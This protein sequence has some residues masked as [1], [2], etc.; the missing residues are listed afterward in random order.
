MSEE[1]TAY[2]LEDLEGFSDTQLLEILIR[3]WGYEQDKP[4]DLLGKLK[5]IT[6]NAGGS[7]YILEQ[8]HSVID[9]SILAYPL[10]E[11][12]VRQT[13]FVGNVKNRELEPGCWVKARVTLAPETV[14]IKHKNPFS[15]KTVDDS[16]SLLFALPETADSAKYYVEDKLHVE[17]WIV[18]FYHSKN[19]KQ[20]AE[21]KELLLAQLSQD[22]KRLEQEVKTLT[23]LEQSIACEINTSRDELTKNTQDLENLLAEKYDQQQVFSRQKT[24]LE[25]KLN[26]LREY[27]KNT[28]EMLLDLDLISQDDVGALLE[29]RIASQRIIGHD[30]ELVFDRSERQAITYIQAFMKN[31]GILYR[32]S[33]LEDFF[34]LVRTH[35][36]II[37]AGDSGS[38]KTNLVKSFAEAIGG[39]SIIIP[40]KPNWTSA[41]DLLGYYNPLEQK[42]LT[43]P[44]LDALFEAKQ[45]PEIPYFICLDEMNLARVEYYFADFLSLLEE[46]NHSPEIS[47]YSDS[48]SEHLLSEARNFLA[49]I[50]DSKT[51]MNK[52]DLISF[53]DLMRD[54][55][56]NAKLHELC[57]FR[58]GDSLLKYHARLRKMLQS[59]LSTPAKL[60]LPSNVRII[61]AINVDE[62]THYLSPKILDRAHLIRFSSPLLTDWDEIEQE[63]EVFDLD[64]TL[65]VCFH[66]NELGLRQPYPVFDRNDAL[67]SKLL[68]LTKEYLDRL[69]IEFGL[70]T[71]R[72]ARHYQNAIAPFGLNDEIIFNNII[73]HKVLP[74]M[75]FDG[76]KQV[77]KNLFRKDLLASL[78]DYLQIELP[79]IASSRVHS[80]IDELDRVIRNAESNDWIVNYWSR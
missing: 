68:H 6:L 10:A 19:S 75:M 16:L 58:D 23:E 65:P 64:M 1:Y 11:E 24:E 69:G 26:K 14:R 29:Q 38:G 40:V 35:D 22:K 73:L 61:G 36:L 8:L 44:F 79:N 47:L 51:K 32:R 28:A 37:L 20:I 17:N 60:V 55:R 41:E 72:Q 77:G 25:H 39:K 76:E 7:F 46:R 66:P 2:V 12:G 49:L 56:V 67:I 78:K 43:T 48:D 30:F 4:L 15:L 71:V 53:L 54:E 74:K 9:G 52:P 13:V 70:R 3:C 31:K 63:I 57:G 59:Y 21:H 50:N 34:A 42:Y 5:E 80:C 27:I 18:D 33:V 62:T 45:N